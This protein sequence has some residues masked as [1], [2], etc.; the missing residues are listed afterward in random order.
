MDADDGLFTKDTVLVLPKQ[1][2]QKNTMNKSTYY[3][4]SSNGGNNISSTLHTT[5][6][7]CREHVAHRNT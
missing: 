3:V 7:Y 1:S 5:N 6:N 4:R 2:P